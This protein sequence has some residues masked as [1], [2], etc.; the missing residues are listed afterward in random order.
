MVRK[1]KIYLAIFKPEYIINCS[2]MLYN[3]SLQ[4][5]PPVFLKLSIF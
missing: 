3:R 5:I 1:V 4:L 2:H